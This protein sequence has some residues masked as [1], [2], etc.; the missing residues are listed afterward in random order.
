MIKNGKLTCP[1]CESG[2][3]QERQVKNAFLGELVEIA[4]Q[5]TCNDCSATWS[6]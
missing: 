3:V 4:V 1:R 6:C 5:G 2:N